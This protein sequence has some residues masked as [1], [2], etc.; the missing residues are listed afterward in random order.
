MRDVH[1]SLDTRWTIDLI[2]LE[3]H[4]IWSSCGQGPSCRLFFFLSVY[5]YSCNFD[6]S[7][8]AEAGAVEVKRRSYRRVLEEAPVGQQGH[9]QPQSQWACVS[10]WC[11]HCADLQP[12]DKDCLPC[13]FI[14]H[15][16]YWKLCFDVPGLALTAWIEKYKYWPTVSW[17]RLF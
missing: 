13:A 5:Y 3:Q 14:H 17:Y 10:W 6:G 11:S 7:S 15:Y 12:R 4:L 2:V 1:V 16:M 9:Y 8:E